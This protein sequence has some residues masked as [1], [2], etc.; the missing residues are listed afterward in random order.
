LQI[1]QGQRGLGADQG[2]FK[3]PFG[4]GKVHQSVTWNSVIHAGESSPI[5]GPWNSAKPQPRRG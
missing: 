1:T 5:L 3:N 2:R 4:V